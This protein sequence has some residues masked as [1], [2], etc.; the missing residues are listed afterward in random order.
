VEIYQQPEIIAWSCQLVSSY[1]KWLGQ[2][3]V[4]GNDD[5]VLAKQLFL[6]PFVVVSH[7]T[8]ADPVLN[9]GNQAALDLWELPWDRFTQTPSQQTAE[10]VHREERGQM[11]A[12]LNSRGYINNYQ[13]IRISSR[14][15]R[16]SIHHAIV[17]NVVDADGNYLGQAASFAHWQYL[18]TSSN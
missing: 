2:D 11:L 9:Y 6:A 4:Q 14:G 10:P 13:G 17:W 12:Q 8:Q 3:L 5:Q 15:R 18:E 16:F 1:R 7:G